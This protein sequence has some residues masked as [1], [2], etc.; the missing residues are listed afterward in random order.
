[1]E[2]RQGL[3]V[4]PLILIE[5]NEI[6]FD[7]VRLY[8]ADGR[9][10]NFK[11]MIDEHGVSE[12]T[13][14]DS[15]AHLE[16]WIQWVTA[17][18]GKA[19]DEHR[20][21]RLGDFVRSQVPQ[22]WE[23]LEDCGLKVGAI[24]PM[25]AA[26]RLAKPAFFV[27]DPWTTTEVA[28]RPV[29]TRLYRAIVQA[30]N[31]NA[32]GKLAARTVFDLLGGFLAY[33]APSNYLTYTRLATGGSARSWYRSM[34]LDLLLADVFIAEH[35]RTGPDFASL[36]LNAGAHIQHHY[37]FCAAPYR[38]P[39]RNPEWYVRPGEDPVFDVYSLYDRILGRV[40]HAMPRAR[41]MLAT[42]LHQN[43]QETLTFYWRLREHDK[44]L[45][46]IGV[47]FQRVE[48]RMS[49]DFLVVCS[50]DAEAGVASARLR[51]AQA[52]DGTPLFEVDNRGS[53]VF[54]MLTYPGDIKKGF[55]IRV[56]N[57]SFG[58][59]DADVAFVAIKNG[60]HNGIG[61]FID[62]GER[63]PVAPARF[64]LADLPA[65]IASTFNVQL[66]LEPSAS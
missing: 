43:P 30:V 16:P 51:E 10:P 61:Y 19:F 63:A 50:S 56:G 46:K 11:T 15:Y 7:F 53:D 22:I 21:F 57:E 8:A 9:L 64:P 25:N 27:P 18:T 60:E 41:L 12:T 59:F 33:A 13:S 29:L 65:R 49:R 2:S 37:M 6:N 3:D 34:F 44:F 36:F 26:N 5:F 1:L 17:H 14:E 52:A 35:R 62:S 4:S 24:S 20:V 32:Q 39:H 31:D 54:V 23:Q 45:R 42:G 66:R 28:A 40:R 55:G 58:D 47:S 38:G 48:P